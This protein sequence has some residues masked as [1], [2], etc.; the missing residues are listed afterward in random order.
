MTIAIFSN[1]KRCPERLEKALQKANINPNLIEK[2]K[3]LV[4]EKGK[5]EGKRKCTKHIDRKLK[6]KNERYIK[7]LEI[8]MEQQIIVALSIA[9]KQDRINFLRKSLADE[10]SMLTIHYC[11]GDKLQIPKIFLN[12]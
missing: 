5:K 11:Y 9:E 10:N 8:A 4:A 1:N 6:E 3:T 12:L 2:Y 7:K